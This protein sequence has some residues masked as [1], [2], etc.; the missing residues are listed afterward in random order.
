MITAAARDAMSFLP[1]NSRAT[2]YRLASLA[3]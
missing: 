1:E 3:G 2:C